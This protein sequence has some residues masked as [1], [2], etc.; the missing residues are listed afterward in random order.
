ML[1][2]SVILKDAS[3]AKFVLYNVVGIIFLKLI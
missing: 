2:K 3:E 1:F